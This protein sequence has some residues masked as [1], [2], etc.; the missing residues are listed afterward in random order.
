MHKGSCR[1]RT[2]LID[3]GDFIELRS[4]PESLPK[5]RKEMFSS[6]GKDRSPGLHQSIEGLQAR[7]DGLLR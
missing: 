4:L 1:S 3:A 5:L 7:V 6:L 2:F